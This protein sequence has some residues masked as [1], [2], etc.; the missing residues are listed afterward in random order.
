M[1]G[2]RQP[3]AYVHRNFLFIAVLAEI[4]VYAGTA[5]SQA[6]TVYVGRRGARNVLSHFSFRQRPRDDRQYLTY[7]DAEERIGFHPRQRYP[8]ARFYR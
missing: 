4:Y 8:R 3:G 7:R 6:K 2:K 5:F 1:G